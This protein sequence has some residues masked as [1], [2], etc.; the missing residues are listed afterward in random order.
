MTKQSITNEMRSFYKLLDDEAL[1][2]AKSFTLGQSITIE[3]LKIIHELYKSIKLTD[4]EDDFFESAYHNPITSDVEFFLARIFYHVSMLKKL[5]WKI[6]LRRQENKCAPD[7]R[8]ERNNK[9]IGIIEI[10]VKV[11][12]IQQFFSDKRVQNDLKRLEEGKSNFDPYKRIEE[13]KGQIDKYIK[14]FD[15]NKQGIF[16]LVVSLSNVHRKKNNEGLD[17]YKK[18]FKNN[19]GLEISNLVLLSNNLELD[20][21]IEGDYSKYNP[22]SDFEYMLRYLNKL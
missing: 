20:L 3:I 6:Y 2:L 8:I 16:M 22:S 5:N 14:V 1:C 19:S 7:I 15:I 9:T 21:S 12:W 13:I 18:T 17:Y 11:G 4:Y 10:K